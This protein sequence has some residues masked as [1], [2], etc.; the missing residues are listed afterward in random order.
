M[1]G[2]GPPPVPQAACPGLPRR[3]TSSAPTAALIV[4]LAALVATLAFCADRIHNGDFFLQLLGGRFVSLHGFAS[5]DPFP[6]ISQ[7]HTW[8]NQQ[9]LSELSFYWVARAIGFTGLAVAYAAL[10]AFPLLLLLWSCRSKGP[11]MLVI[12]A[13]F[14]LPVVLSIAH[15]R[16]A[17]FTVLAFSTLVILMTAAL[18]GRFPPTAG[19]RAQLWWILIPLLFALW[20]NLH[21]GFVAGLLLVAAVTTGSLLDR[22]RG[23]QG[24]LDPVAIAAIAGSGLLAVLTI[25]IATPLGTQ[26]W[27]YIFSFRNA[28]I[29]VVSSEWRSS[30]HSPAATLYLGAAAL[31]VAWL[32]S[33]TPAPRRF[34]PLL[35]AGAFIAFGALAL[36]NLVYVGPGIVMLIACSAPDRVPGRGRRKSALAAVVAGLAALLWVTA[37]EPPRNAP[38]L[39]SALVSYAIAHPPRAGL[40]ATY[41]GTGSYILWRSPHTPVVLNGWLEHF[42]AAQL[43]GTYGILDARLRDPMPSVRRLG[44]GAVIAVRP[45]AIRSLREH[46][47]VTRFAD[48][49]GAYLVKRALGSRPGRRNGTMRATTG[50]APARG[51]HVE[52]SRQP[53]HDV[54]VARPPGQ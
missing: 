4:S 51:Q 3:P 21:G 2:L 8:L 27:S 23:L 6:T 28:G 24:A 38:P 10:L 40:I 35:I 54:A 45:R 33:R 9:W 12:G 41:A 34:T 11:V 37:A 49:N 30:L 15:P 50:Q 46:G 1:G 48:R 5:Q 13:A 17:G 43:R 42:S 53:A 52:A 22:R 20:A 26:I 19:I 47:F 14:Y 36:R 44:I 29:A 25:T 7:G 16:A 18:R 32:W 31:L 39:G